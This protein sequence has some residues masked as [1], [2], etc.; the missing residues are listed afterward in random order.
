MSHLIWDFDKDEVRVEEE[1][2]IAKVDYEDDTFEFPGFKKIPVGT[3][4]T[5]IEQYDKSK[6]N[7]GLTKGVE[8]VTIEY[9]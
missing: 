8:E 6:R 3:I 7:K 9:R 5:L 2:K 1:V 4:R